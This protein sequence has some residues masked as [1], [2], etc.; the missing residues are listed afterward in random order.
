MINFVSRLFDLLAPRSCV[1]CGARLTTGE[2]T[3]CATCN[4]HL[5]R[6]GFAADTEDN[7]LCRVFWGRLPVERCGAL[8]YYSAGSASSRLILSLKYMRRPDVGIA[9]GRMMAREYQAAGFFNGIDAILPVPLA[10][11][12]LRQRGYNQSQ[13]IAD[14]VH[15]ITALP[16]IDRALRRETFLESQTQKNRWER[17]DNVENIF[18][19]THP[20]LLKGRHLLLIDDVVTSGA[21]LCA[22]GQ[23]A[24]K[25]G[26]VRLSILTL[27]FSKS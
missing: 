9:L 27:G 6:T 15:E 14:G 19:L 23:E 2:D 25:A 22:C 26:D 16:V 3:L 4:L 24:L 7:E 12:R 1:V 10:T 17:A 5:P 11:N 8:F 21:T 13:M 18:R 20:E